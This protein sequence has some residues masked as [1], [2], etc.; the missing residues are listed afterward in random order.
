VIEV[1][2]ACRNSWQ[3]LSGMTVMRVGIPL[4]E[5]EAS[6]RLIG[7]PRHARAEVLSGALL[8]QDEMLAEWGR[9][10]ARA[11]RKK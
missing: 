8:M 9:Q 1:M 10:A 3:W 2:Q 5:I 4:I 6:M 11:S 7:I